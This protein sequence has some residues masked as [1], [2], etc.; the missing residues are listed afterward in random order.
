M[1]AALLASTLLATPCAA[2]P[3]S[4]AWNYNSCA[5]PPLRVASFPGNT[6]GDQ[7]AA[8]VAA[9]PATGGVCDAR[10][11]PSGGLIPAMT[12]GQSGVTLLGP[13][14]VFTVT[15]SIQIYSTS[16]V[17]AFK[18]EMCGASY[19]TF[20]THLLWG[21][22]A[23]DPMFRLRGVRD[24][25]L[26]EFSIASNQFVPLAEAIR[27][28]TATGTTSTHRH[29]YNV[30]IN[31][32]A[33]GGLGKAIRWCIGDDCGGAGADNNNDVDRIDSVLASNYTNAAFSLE[34]TQV[35]GIEFYGSQMLGNGIGARGVATTQAANLNRNAGSFA[36]YGGGGGGNS[37]A[38]FDL[39]AP[40]NAIL[41]S[42]GTWESSNRLLSAGVNPGGSAWPITIMGGRW[43]ADKLNA[44]NN[45]IIYKY[46]GPLNIL[47]E[48]IDAAQPGAA[49]QFNMATDG[50]TASANAIGVT[51]RNQSATAQTNPFVGN[52][53]Y[54]SLMGN[55]VNDNMGNIYRVPNQ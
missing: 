14:G 7:I 26:S 40:N 25:S 41:I 52:G 21:G 13:C 36:W 20:G 12:I 5:Y 54:W 44:D 45:V 55:T 8:C 18:W 15:G 1:K 35:Q 32:T 9:L 53:S 6:V 11:I 43:S 23:T 28:E 31:G 48:I 37:V 24:S 29:I 10:D 33:A 42:G 47:G 46:R 49:P 17:S 38:D 51:V 2:L 50:G 39:G 30:I 22:D 34:G 4:Q 3:C 27:F 19:G 16:G